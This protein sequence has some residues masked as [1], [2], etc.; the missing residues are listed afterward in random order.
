MSS[1]REL[2]ASVVKFRDDRDWAQFH[3]PKDVVLS[4]MLE[5]GELAEHMQWKNG[6][7]LQKHLE[8]KREDVAEELSDV[9]YW[10]LL[11]AHDLKIDLSAAF[12]KKLAKNDEKYPVE[13]SFGNSA[14]YTELK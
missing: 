1:I 10:T 11:L 12:Q 2:T 7:E 14:K 4:L 8:E 3:T 6:D 5:A 13:K 9:L